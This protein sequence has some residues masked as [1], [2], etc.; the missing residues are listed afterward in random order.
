MI[1]DES[2]NVVKGKK[3]EAFGNIVWEEGIHEDN[4]EF[5]GKEKDPTGF[6]YF[7]ARRYYGNIGRFLSPD[8]HTVSPGNIRLNDPQSSN[9]YVYSRN[10]P[11]TL[12]DPDGRVL[13]KGGGQFNCLLE[14]RNYNLSS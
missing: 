6:H 12:Y 13:E 5:T 10:N 4:R 8:P 7:G 14:V 2:G 1:T 11:V 3:Y 9:P